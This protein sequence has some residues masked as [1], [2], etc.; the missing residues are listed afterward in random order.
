MV[1]LE[2]CLLADYNCLIAKPLSV[3]VNTIRFICVAYKSGVLHACATMSR[4]PS[5]HSVYEPSP[6]AVQHVL[7]AVLHV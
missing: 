1:I 6:M 5:L 7:F 3:Q 2:T 4:F